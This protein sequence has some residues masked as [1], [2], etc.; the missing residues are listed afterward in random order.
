MQLWIPCPPRAA[1]ST[2][3]MP[4]Y[5]SA[6]RAGRRLTSGEPAAEGRRAAGWRSTSSAARRWTKWPSPGVRIR[7]TTGGAENGAHFAERAGGGLVGGGGWGGGT[8]GGS[9]VGG[10]V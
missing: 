9:A 7:S 4:T 3:I 10:G 2:L 6:R 8:G 5:G 1:P